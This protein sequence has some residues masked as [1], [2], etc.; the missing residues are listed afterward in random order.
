MDTLWTETQ[1][2][3][4]H[5]LIEVQ[6][7]AEEERVASL[8]L[9][10]HRSQVAHKMNQLH[11][12]VLEPWQSHVSG[13]E[14]RRQ[15]QTDT[16]MGTT[17]SRNKAEWKQ[18]ASPAYQTKSRVRSGGRC[19]Q[20]PSGTT[21][22]KRGNVICWYWTFHWSFWEVQTQYWYNQKNQP[23]PSVWILS[24]SSQTAKQ[25]SHW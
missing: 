16:S 19:T 21:R 18:V 14:S 4:I 11:H 2:R 20:M 5:R 17:M 23:L 7:E 24:L 15:S 1:H 22:K 12:R 13:T 10:A 3:F 8:Q 6:D 9:E 25:V